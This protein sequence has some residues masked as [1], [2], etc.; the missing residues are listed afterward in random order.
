[1]AAG[2]YEAVRVLLDGVSVD[3]GLLTALS[4]LSLVIQGR[5][6]NTRGSVSPSCGQGRLTTRWLEL[7]TMLRLSSWLTVMSP[8]RYWLTS[9]GPSHRSTIEIPQV[10]NGCLDRY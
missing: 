1:M 9:P 3:I 8:T 5:M 7:R 4:I 2:V 10:G 6:K